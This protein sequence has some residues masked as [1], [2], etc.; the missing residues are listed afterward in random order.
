MN[1]PETVD[2][3]DLMATLRAI[4]SV[5]ADTIEHIDRL[6][7]DDLSEEEMHSLRACIRW[8]ALIGYRADSLHGA[9]FPDAADDAVEYGL[10]WAFVEFANAAVECS[11]EVAEMMLQ[12][13]DLG[14]DGRA[15]VE[16]YLRGLT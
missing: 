9:V 6:D 4:D 11:R 5:L 13:D 12:G 7:W 16:A 8:A 10:P 15:F 1:R 2:L 3:E 14:D